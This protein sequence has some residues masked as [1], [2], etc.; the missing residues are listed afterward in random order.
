[1]FV[2]SF[3]SHSLGFLKE[4]NKARQL[5]YLLLTAPFLWLRGC[6]CTM[7]WTI[8][9]NE[10]HPLLVLRQFAICCTHIL[11]EATFFANS[12]G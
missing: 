4:I 5:V 10:E 9:Y 6:P 11:F 2:I 8:I 1:M 7:A 12:V 3:C